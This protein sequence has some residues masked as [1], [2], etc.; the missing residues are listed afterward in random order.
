M[1]AVAYDPGAPAAARRGPTAPASAL[2]AGT[3]FHR[4]RAPVEHAFSTAVTFP[5][6]D[7]AELPR[8][9]DG[10]P[11]WSA[12]RP[13]PAWWRRADYLGDPAT[14]L[15]EA[16]RDLVQERTGARPAGPVRLLA[17]PRTWGIGFN[18]VAFYWCFDAAG[19]RVE[20]VVAE[21]TSTPWGERHAYIAPSNGKTDDVVVSRQAKALHLSPLM[22][23]EQEYV[24]RMGRPGESLAISIASEQ[25]GATVFEA[26]LSLR[27]RALT[28]RATTRAL[29]QHP[30]GSAQ[31]L[32][33][34][35]WHALRLRLKGVPWH[36]KPPASAAPAPAAAAPAAA[37]ARPA[38]PRSAASAEA[39]R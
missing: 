11:L 20:A 19:E 30:G 27:R 23:M 28:P 26:G 18:P 10:H 15:A 31:V 6:L 17:Q 25:D 39:R 29:L 13:A 5:L 3:L 9:F 32:A 8:I 36:A 1:S 34:I 2:Y 37:A 21:V 7:L 14:P 12:R 24:W 38:R 33:Q 16:V 22:A 4:R 35:Y